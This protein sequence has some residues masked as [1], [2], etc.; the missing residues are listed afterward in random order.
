MPRAFSYSAASATTSVPPGS[1]VDVVVVVVAQL[2]TAA[3]RASKA[4]D[5]RMMGIRFDKQTG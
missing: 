4:I 3:Q 1:I 5:L 2:D